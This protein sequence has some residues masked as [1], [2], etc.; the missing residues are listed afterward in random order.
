MP[1]GS[2]NINLDL[3]LYHYFVLAVVVFMNILVFITDQKFERKKKN[4]EREREKN[5]LSL[6]KIMLLAYFQNSQQ[7]VMMHSKYEKIGRTRKCTGCGL[8]CPGRHMCQH[9]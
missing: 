2:Q 5:A 4:R 1:F 8:S 6:C 9:C 7:T 3:P